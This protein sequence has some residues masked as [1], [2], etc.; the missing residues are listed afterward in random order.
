M[1]G[2]FMNKPFL[3]FFPNVF[4]IDPEQEWDE[5]SVSNSHI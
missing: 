5:V 2:Y 4:I 1:E 3:I